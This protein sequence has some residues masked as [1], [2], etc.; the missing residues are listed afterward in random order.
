MQSKSLGDT[1]SWSPYVEEFR[2]KHE[3]KLFVTTFWNNLFNQSY[4]NLIFDATLSQPK[5][6]IISATPFLNGTPI[7]F[8]L[9][10][11]KTPLHFLHFSEIQCSDNL[12]LQNSA[13]MI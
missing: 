13:F 11:I 1:L 7:L 2:K 8:L 5:L 4:K 10:F 9:F 3:C 6:T 12:V